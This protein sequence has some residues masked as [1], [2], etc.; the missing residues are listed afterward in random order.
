M[1]FECRLHRR[2]E[3]LAFVP[4]WQSDECLNYT[5]QGVANGH[6]EQ[7]IAHFSRVFPERRQASQNSKAG[8]DGSREELGPQRA[9]LAGH[10]F[11]ELRVSF[12]RTML[13]ELELKMMSRGK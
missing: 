9:A 6:N 12:D 1:L 8:R 7:P 10:L 2:S 13:L 5:R 3:G 4:T 11:A